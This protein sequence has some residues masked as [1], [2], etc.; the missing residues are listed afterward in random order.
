[1]RKH[2]SKISFFLLE[3]RVEKLQAKAEIMGNTTTFT[4]EYR[5]GDKKDVS[6]GDAVLLLQTPEA[7]KVKRFLCNSKGQGM[8]PTLLND[9]LP[10]AE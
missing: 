6:A 7:E 8:L 1:M 4:A 2:F 3:K 5:N 10:D 9:L